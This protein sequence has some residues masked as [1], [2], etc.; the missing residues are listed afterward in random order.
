MPVG[1]R[2]SCVAK[3]RYLVLKQNRDRFHQRRIL[4]GSLSVAALAGH[5]H[6]AEL[7]QPTKDVRP[8]QGKYFVVVGKVAIS[9]ANALLTLQELS[10]PQRQLIALVTNALARPVKALASQDGSDYQTVG[11]I[12]DTTAQFATNHRLGAD[13]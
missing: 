7:W 2:T 12:K 6:Q 1:Q 11:A 9:L 10:M 5:N 13:T 4:L 3:Q 8:K